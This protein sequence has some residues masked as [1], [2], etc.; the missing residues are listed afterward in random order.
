MDFM[1]GSSES[2]VSNLKHA[3]DMEPPPSSSSSS[4]GKNGEVLLSN[5]RLLSRALVGEGAPSSSSSD[6]DYHGGLSGDT[7]LC[8][9]TVLLKSS[10]VIVRLLEQVRILGFENRKELAVIFKSLMR[11][12]PESFVEYLVQEDQVHV[13]DA[14]WAGYAEAEAAL[15]CGVMLR[16][17][18]R[19][20]SFAA[21]VLRRPS[22]W[23]VLDEYIHD[24]GFD[25]ASDAFNTLVELVMGPHED[26]CATFLGERFEDFFGRFESLLL[27]ENYMVRRRSLKLL[28]ELLLRRSNMHVMRR[29]VGSKHFLKV[30][31]LLLRDK[32]SNI[33]FEAFHVFKIFVANPDKQ[34][35]II[36]VL[37]RNK[38]KLISY[39]DGFRATLSKDKDKEKSDAAAQLEHEK[40]MLIKILGNL[41]DESSLG[42]CG[43]S[44]STTLVPDDSAACTS[45]P[46]VRA[47]S[48]A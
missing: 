13:V 37:V 24:P 35:D 36:E 10:G 17:A 15:S 48:I 27:S 29:F 44:P 30:I 41:P 6:G 3:L 7:E 9:M 4:S 22:L 21:A 39:L 1:E 31:M 32:S 43:T 38:S 20:V 16:S 47:P 23:A 46:P 33:Q 25:V 14:L 19:H 26:L 8:A 2:V 5:L 11:K 18:V 34:S 42:Q 12:N 28:G 40:E 45:T